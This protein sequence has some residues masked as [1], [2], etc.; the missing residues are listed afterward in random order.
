MLSEE[1]KNKLASIQSEEPDKID[2]QMLK[3]AG[4]INADGCEVRADEYFARRKNNAISLRIPYSLREQLQ[5][6]ADLE[7]VSLNQYCMY[8]LTAGIASG[9]R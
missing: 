1:L 2:L 4:E 3:D 9:G 5:A 6:N 8:L 7:G